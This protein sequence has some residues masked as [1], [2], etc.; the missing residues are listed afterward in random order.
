MPSANLQTIRVKHNMEM[1][2][3]LYQTPGKCQ[4]IHGHSWWCTLSLQGEVSEQGM[5]VEFGDLKKTFRAFLDGSFDHKLL[6]NRHDKFIEMAGGPQAIPGL[7]AFAYDPTTENIAKYIGEHM[8][9][10]LPT[11]IRRVS[12][13]LWE[14]SVNCATWV[15]EL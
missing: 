1:A 11:N 9:A 5:V 12:I 6:L 7:N 4:Q 3:R 2:H 10:Q 14:T 15:A 8:A 13:E